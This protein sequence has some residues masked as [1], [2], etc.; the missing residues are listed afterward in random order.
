MAKRSAIGR[1]A[2]VKT[3]KQFADELSSYTT[4]TSNEI[5]NLFPTKSD[6]EELMELIKIVNSDASDKE[7]KA[8][9]IEKIGKISGA[10]IKI[11]KKFAICI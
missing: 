3:K 8:K 9:L 11:G 10:V 5:Q 6:R 1:L 7:K 4:L 2:S